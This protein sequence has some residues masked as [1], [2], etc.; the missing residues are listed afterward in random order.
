M[1]GIGFTRG[2]SFAADWRAPTLTPLGLDKIPEDRFL[3][4]RLARLKPMQTVHEDEALA[5]AAD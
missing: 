3:A 5:V 2:P 4:Q 1:A